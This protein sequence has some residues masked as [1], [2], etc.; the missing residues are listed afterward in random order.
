MKMDHTLHLEMCFI[1][2]NNE[3]LYQHVE[4]ELNKW[5]GLPAQWFVHR[6]QEQN[7][8]IVTAE[9][10]SKGAWESE[11]VL[12]NYVEDHFQLE[13]LDQ[14]YGYHVQSDNKQEGGCCGCGK[15]G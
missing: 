10:H 1:S 8:Q 11:E 14:L 2:E 7:L 6:K 4:S 12:L 3:L 13:L 15:V 9:V 5:F